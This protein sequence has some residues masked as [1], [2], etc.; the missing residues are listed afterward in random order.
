MHGRAKQYRLHEIK[1]K[2]IWKQKTLLCLTVLFIRFWT[3]VVLSRFVS[4]FSFLCWLFCLFRRDVWFHY[5]FILGLCVTHF[6]YPGF[7]FILSLFCFMCCLLLVYSGLILGSFLVY[8]WFLLGSFWIYCWLIL[9]L[10]LAC[11]WFILSLFRISSEY[12]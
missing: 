4:L 2:H 12:A 10:F 9:A 6:S 5:W 11:S 1:A 3:S 7:S 8:S